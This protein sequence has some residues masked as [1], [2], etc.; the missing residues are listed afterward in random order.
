[1]KYLKRF[2]DFCGGFAAFC[3]IIYSI[4][5]F[6]MY[7]PDEE[8]GTVEKVKFF[9]FGNYSRNFNAYVVMIALFAISVIIGVIFER[10]PFV[11]LSVSL[12]PLMWTLFMY[13][14]E[15][16]YE[17]PMLYV[18]LALVHTS[19]SIIYAVLL[20]KEDGKRRAFWCVNA[21]G[22]LIGAL[23]LAIWRRSAVLAATELTDDEIRELSDIDGEIFGGLEDGNSA[24]ILLFIGIILLVTVVISI[25]LIDLYYIDVILCLLPLLYS[26]WAFF[27]EL[28]AVFGGAVFTVIAAYFVMRVLVMTSEPTTKEESDEYLQN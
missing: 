18:I 28:L 4:G 2:T 22:T 25:L 17:K 16:L 13:A 19:G 7:N 27:T 8:L 12:L 26:L 1:M 10:F 3:A 20:D 11:S 9:F 24:K 15:W 6:I 5:Q 14:S 23:C 21:V